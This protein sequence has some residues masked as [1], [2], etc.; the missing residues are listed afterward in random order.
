M[1]ILWQPSAQFIAQSNLTAYAR[2]L[3]QRLGLRFESYDVLWRWSVSDLE[4]FWASI[5][6]YFDVQA[7]QPYTRVLMRREMPGAV[8]FPGARLNYAAHAF[9]HA[10]DAQPALIAH[11]ETTTHR[12]ATVSISW[13]ALRNDVA[14]FAAWLR[15]IGVRSGDRVAAYMPNIPEAVIAFLACA[16]IGAIWSSCAPDLGAVAALDRFRQIEPRV[17]LAV[18]GYLYNG[19]PFDRRA[20]VAEII[21]ALPGLQHVVRVPYLHADDAPFNVR[22]PETRWDEVLAQFTD[23]PSLSFE[24]LP[25]DH[26][27][28][29]L[30][31]S[32]TT[33][34]PKPIVQ[35]H[36][37]I[38]LEHLKALALHLDLKPEDRFFW[39]T[40]TG[41]MM[42]NFLVSGLLL[43]STILLYDG[44]PALE[45]MLALW[46]F[47]EQTEMTLFG[48]S[49]AFITA[50]MKAGVEPG[51]ACNLSALRSVGSTGSPLSV[52]GFR[53]VYE[54]VKREVWLAPISGGTDVCTAFV[55]GCPWLPVR[56]GEMQCRFLGAD[57][58]VFD[59]QG[60]PIVG[61]MGELV[62]CQP[63]PSMPIYFWN[64]PDFRR[65]RESY[66]EVYP[67]VW[68]HGD[69]ATITESGG[70]VIH[71]RSDATLKRHG[72]RIGTSE[73][74]RV[75]EAL[76][77]VQEA[78]VI[79]LERQGGEAVMLLF[80]VTRPNVTLD[81]A[82]RNA[83]RK[84]IR[85]QLSP[86]YVPD[87]IIAVP[88]VPRTLNGKK[89]EVPVKRLL[90]GVP[91]EKAANL[92]STANPEALTFFAQFA[93]RRTPHK[94]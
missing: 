8:W 34:L 42:W 75:V 24:P 3:E 17:L 48:T 67:G 83:I 33:G 84:A 74:Y 90:L 64:D 72:V 41:W 31:S 14:R 13:S 9:R 94:A 76:P 7:A 73:I 63:L 32:G 93:Q 1:T 77:E 6:E 60:K 81:D 43:G 21:G 92:G 5:W 47:A 69:W 26:P 82:L 20:L 40:T 65:Y 2:W 61:S 85:E 15:A 56:A 57:V 66:F 55:G 88:D 87:E 91:L 23:P 38:L 19:K 45:D 89:M 52:E 10:R 80:V 79:D 22:V 50:C 86:R 18:D 37:G 11:T 35:S 12:P 70:V 71:G 54:H 68:R 62:V 28:W 30:Y 78:L 49:A 4:T 59:D 29:V 16:S 46:R 25:F 44:S 27:L 36:G 51:R 58:Q 53:W 39:F